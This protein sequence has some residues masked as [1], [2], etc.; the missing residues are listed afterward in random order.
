M[1]KKKVLKAPKAH[2]SATNSV[3]QSRARR[4]RDKLR[5]MCKDIDPPP[6]KPY[7]PSKAMLEAEERARACSN[8]KRFQLA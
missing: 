3:V 4:S 7:V 6:F 5:E 1:T 8:P 2:A